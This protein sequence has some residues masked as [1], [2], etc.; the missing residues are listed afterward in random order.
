MAGQLDQDV[1]AV[2]RDQCRHLGIAAV[3]DVVP[4]AGEAAQLAGDVVRLVDIG[5]DGHL[6]R[7]AVVMREHRADE[8]ADRMADR[9]GET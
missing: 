9:T 5:I 6:D 4:A 1:D 7:G 2:G 3:M 8:V